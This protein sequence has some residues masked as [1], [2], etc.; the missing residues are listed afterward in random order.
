MLLNKTSRKQQR[1]MNYLADK[2]LFGEKLSNLRLYFSKIIC[3]IVSKQ[4]VLYILN[5][6]K[7]LIIC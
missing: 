6:I 5:K 4:L 7:R 3:R 2:L 1:K